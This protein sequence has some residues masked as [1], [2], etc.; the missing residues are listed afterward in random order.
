MTLADYLLEVKPLSLHARFALGLRVFER[1]VSLRGLQDSSV[2]SYLAE[3]WEYPLIHDLEDK[4]CLAAYTRWKHDG[5]CSADTIGPSRVGVRSLPRNSRLMKAE[6]VGA[7]LSEVMTAA[8]KANKDRDT[9][10]LTYWLI[11]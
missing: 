2:W 5:E 9:C 7:T 8:R 3:M 4:S 10:L 6:L 11:D 1:Y